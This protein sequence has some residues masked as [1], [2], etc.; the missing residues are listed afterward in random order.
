MFPSGN[1]PQ[2]VGL[3]FTPDFWSNF[4]LCTVFVSSIV[5]LVC[6]LVRLGLL[7]Q[8]LFLLFLPQH[9]WYSKQVYRTVERQLFRG[10]V[11]Q[12]FLVLQFEMHFLEDRNCSNCSHKQQQRSILVSKTDIEFEAEKYVYLERNK[13]RRPY[14]KSEN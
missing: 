10:P 11:I 3:K 2:I 8:T 1:N 12:L 4:N 5:N 6:I 9:M 13:G 14:T 7:H